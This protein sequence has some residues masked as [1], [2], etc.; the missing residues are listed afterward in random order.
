MLRIVGGK[1]R[2]RRI[3]APTGDFARP[4][5]DRVREALFS[6]LTS[7]DVLA[8][9]RVLD[10]CAGSGALGLEAL[11]RGA[12][13]VTFF[14]TSRRAL[15]VISDNIAALGEQATT[16][17]RQ[18]DATKPPHAPAPCSLI[19]IDAPYRS[20]IAER[21]LPALAA[22]GWFAT[23]ALIVIETARD[24]A[25]ALPIGFHETDRRSYGATQLLFVEYGAE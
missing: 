17:V 23:E 2:G 9:A 19:L 22:A 4:T 5:T 25:P 6:I 16:E 13:H 3:A 14:D 8:D 20:D 21:A 18:A 15:G 1:H 12:A 7:K 10:A 24:G 11:S